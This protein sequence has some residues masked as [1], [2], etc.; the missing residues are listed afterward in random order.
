[1]F[2]LYK[3]GEKDSMG[4]AQPF[5]LYLK[6]VRIQFIGRAS[7]ALPDCQRLPHHNPKL[8]NSHFKLLK[9]PKH[10]DWARCSLRS[11]Y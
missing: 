9:I 1:M 11:L 8:S 10:G 6:C 5:K 4:S 7:I 2:L 3:N